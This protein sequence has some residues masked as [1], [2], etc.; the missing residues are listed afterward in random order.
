LFQEKEMRKPKETGTG[1]NGFPIGMEKP[2]L[3]SSER[4]NTTERQLGLGDLA[5]ETS[6]GVPKGNA[7]K[8]LILGKGGTMK[9]G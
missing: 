3:P 2:L 1:S 5:G 7:R 6:M 9:R 8:I 4:S